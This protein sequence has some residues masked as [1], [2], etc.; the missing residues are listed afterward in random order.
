MKIKAFCLYLIVLSGIGCTRFEKG[1]TEI[2]LA[3]V[4]NKYLY[5]SDLKYLFT[6][7]IAGEDSVL[8]ARNFID[9]WVKEQLLLY[10][11]DENLTEEEKDVQRQLDNYRTSLLIYK[12]KEQI[13]KQ[14]LDTLISQAEIENYY[15]TNSQNFLLEESIVKA[16][17]V[18]V[19]R[20]L[21]WQD[22]SNIRKWSRSSEEADIILLE[23][24]CSQNNGKFD[25]FNDDWIYFRTVQ[26]QFPRNINNP[27]AYFRYND[28]VETYDTTYRYF[29]KVNEFVPKSEVAPID[30]VES[31]IKSILMNKRKLQ[32][33]KDIENNIYNE[34]LNRDNVKIFH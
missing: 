10:K 27:E 20:N 33:L 7:N 8:I 13:V 16:M 26:N 29:L 19:D 18:K 22:L 11:A 17:I 25:R 1:N 5:P 3:R 6:E 12:Y 28:F 4:Y 24:Y 9:S 14:K 30:F 2:P 21:Q 31:E 15:T 34:A 23:N 32:L